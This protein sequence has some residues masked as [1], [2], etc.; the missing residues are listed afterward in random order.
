[1]TASVEQALLSR[2][3]ELAE[4][5]LVDGTLWVAPCALT[6]RRAALLRSVWHVAFEKIYAG[7]AGEAGDGLHDSVWGDSYTGAFLPRRQIR[8]WIDRT[9][10]N[11]RALGPRRVLEIGCGDGQI[12]RGLLPHCQSYVG[13]D[14]SAA[15]VESIQERLS[16][17]QRQRVELACLDAM[18]VGQL[19]GPFDTIV[20]N[21]VCQYFPSYDYFTRLLDVLGPLLSPGGAVYLGDL[22]STRARLEL[23]ASIEWTLG[24]DRTV[25]GWREAVRRRL[26]EERELLFDPTLA[27]AL[28]A[29]WGQASVTLKR[30]H[31]DN[32]LANFRFDLVVRRAPVERGSEPELVD[33]NSDPSLE[34]LEQRLREGQTDW[35]VVTSVPNARLVRHV[36]RLVR[37]AQAPGHLRL[38][39]VPGPS[40]GGIDPEAL[41]ALAARAGRRA[42]VGWSA[43]PGCADA[44]FARPGAAALAVSGVMSSSAIV[45]LSNLPSFG[46]LATRLRRGVQEAL[47]DLGVDVPVRVL[48]RLPR[49][50]SGAFDVTAAHNEWVSA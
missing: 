27:V 49:A 25:D 17:D 37:L 11:I 16:P 8:A 40:E 2:L 19:R 18:E 45:P 14:I 13:T 50:A 26:V 33:W 4:A 32:E 35:L 46:A 42:V 43:T 12:L 15:A 23:A 30:G 1:V 9:V 3:P 5:E 48:E 47:Q 36:R 10:E 38:S 41:H 20:L 6:E 21:S 31:D 34:S 44:F 22:R 24:P 39:D 28:A 29:R 7:P